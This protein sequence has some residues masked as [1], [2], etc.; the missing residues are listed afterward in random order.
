MQGENLLSEIGEARMDDGKWERLARAVRGGD[1]TFFL[2]MR[3]CR[4]VGMCSVSRCFSTFAW[5]DTGVFDDFFVEPVFRC[6]G[7]AR[8][9]AEAAQVWCRE[10]GLAA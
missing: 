6:Q 2:A 7:G 1:I 3:S 5:D 4:A 10:Q 8:L 9:L